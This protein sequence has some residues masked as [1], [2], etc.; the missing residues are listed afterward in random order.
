M[1]RYQSRNSSLYAAFQRKKQERAN[2]RRKPEPLARLPR[3]TTTLIMQHGRLRHP[4]LKDRDESQHFSYILAAYGYLLAQG[5]HSIQN[6]SDRIAEV[7]DTEGDSGEAAKH[8]HNIAFLQRI[9]H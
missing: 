9:S 5:S 6:L 4:S 8:R 2:Q 7:Y 3:N 1:A